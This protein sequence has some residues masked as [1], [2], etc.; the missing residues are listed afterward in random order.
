MHTQEEGRQPGQTGHET[1][2]QGPDLVKN[3]RDK[4]GWGQSSREEEGG[5]GELEGRRRGVE[6]ETERTQTRACDPTAA[7]RYLVGLLLA[8]GQRQ[9][10]LQLLLPAA[11]WPGLLRLGRGPGAH[12]CGGS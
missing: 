12:G 4:L 3:S 8:H 7:H 5:E 10:Q 6:M 2:S 9:L 1:Q 11:L